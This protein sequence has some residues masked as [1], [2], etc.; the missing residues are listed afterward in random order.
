MLSLFS[1]RGAGLLSPRKLI[2]SCDLKRKLTSVQRSVCN[3]CMSATGKAVDRFPL[4]QR[5]QSGSLNAEF[6]P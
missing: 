5:S 1:A 3:V 6:I 2:G 4:V